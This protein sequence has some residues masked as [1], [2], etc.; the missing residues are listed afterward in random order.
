MWR[1]M[2]LVVLA[3]LVCAALA[4]GDSTHDAG[5]CVDENGEPAYELFVHP[6]I[7]DVEFYRELYQTYDARLDVDFGETTKLTLTIRNKTTEAQT[8]TTTRKLPVSFVITPT[9]CRGFWYSYPGDPYPATRLRFGP[10]EEKKYTSEWGLLFNGKDAVP[11]GTPLF[12]YAF[13]GVRDGMDGERVGAM[14]AFRR[15]R[16]KEKHLR[17]LRIEHPPVP[18]DPS[19][20]GGLLKASRRELAIFY[21]KGIPPDAYLHAANAFVAH[22][23]ELLALRGSNYISEVYTGNLLDENRQAIETMFGIRVVVSEPLPEDWELP[24]PECLEG[25]P[26]QVV[27][28]LDR[29]RYR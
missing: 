11:L 15:I 26:V 13:V 1:W 12:I 17:A 10:G 7:A 27:V 18:V 22:R 23:D 4:C 14:A 24:V 21:E 28:E 29:Y 25:A 2:S 6:V 20:C 3:A 5:P 19:A 9:D 8:L 16:V